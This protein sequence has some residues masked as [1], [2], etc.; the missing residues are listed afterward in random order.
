MV[1]EQKR[2]CAWAENVCPLYQAYHD[3]EW[4]VPV[5]D[6]GKLY[7]MF[8]LE[9]FQAGL[10]WLTIL[11]K[12]EAFRAAFDGFD[13]EKVAAYD[14]RKIAALL[15]DPGIIRC[16]RKIEGAVKNAGIFLA[17][18]REY[19]S[20]DAYL[21][22]FAGE[23]PILHAGGAVPVTTALSDAVSK[24]LKARGMAYVGSVTIYSYLQA[25]GVVNDH[26]T[27]CFC[28]NERI[29]ATKIPPG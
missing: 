8:L 10:S 18:Q 11:R 16:R 12:R 5:H 4:G 19:G 17:I 29:R 6:D 28:R 24:D 27:D 22:S 26:E 20:F 14:E 1:T 13:V 9:T 2:R 7:E 15:A 21:R 25:V 3:G 23:K